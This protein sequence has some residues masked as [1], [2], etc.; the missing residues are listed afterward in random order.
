MSEIDKIQLKDASGQLIGE[1]DLPGGSSTDEKVKQTETTT[2][3]EYE[4]LFSGTADNTTRTEG[5]GKNEGMTYNP[6][7]NALTIGLRDSGSTIGTGSVITGYG[8]TASGIYSHAQGTGAMASGSY[9]HAEGGGTTA[10]GYYSHAEGGGSTASGDT[11]HAEGGGTTASG[12][13]SHAEGGGTIAKNA[14]QHTLGTYNVQ[15]PSGNSSSAKGTYIEIVGNGTENTPSNARTLDW[16]GNETIAGN[17]SAG[18]TIS[19]NGNALGN[20]AFDDVV[21][22]AHGGTGQNTRLKAFKAMTNSNVGSNVTHFVTFTT[23]W[24]SAGYST[25]ANVRGALNIQAGAPGTSSWWNNRA[26]I[27]SS[28]DGV[29]EIGKYIDFHT[30]NNN[31]SDYTF[32]FTNTE[33]GKLTA[34]GTITQGSSRKIKKNIKPMTDE[35]ASKLLDLEPVYFDYIK[36]YGGG[37]D[38]RGFIAEDVKSIL[39]NLVLDESGDE[40]DHKHFLPASLNYIEI[41]PYLVKLCQ[42]QQ[43]QIDYLENRVLALEKELKIGYWEEN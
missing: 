41:I 25:V 40:K 29:M 38:H 12:H 8:N 32:R 2:D 9:S 28:G 18:G 21:T 1:Y 11:S 15:D 6:S 39:P 20:A 30:T 14:Y 16:Q 19:S 31:N 26:P 37:K 43:E 36:E 17:F 4:V 7:Y 23:D 35:E 10:S 13:Y 42:M 33:N 27:I 24:A 22:I 5:A 3:A 34:S